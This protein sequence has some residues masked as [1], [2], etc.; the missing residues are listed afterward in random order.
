M[1]ALALWKGTPQDPDGPGDV[2]G[3][4]GQQRDGPAAEVKRS[5]LYL[6]LIHI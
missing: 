1:A 5:V 3:I 2:R 6:S 4:F